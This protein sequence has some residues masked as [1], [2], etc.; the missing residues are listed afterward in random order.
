MR[1]DDKNTPKMS[2]RGKIGK[3]KIVSDAM[4]LSNFSMLALLPVPL[5]ALASLAHFFRASPLPEDRPDLSGLASVDEGV[6][7]DDG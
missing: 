2:Q 1:G 4:M 7:D 6:E 5:R 3:S